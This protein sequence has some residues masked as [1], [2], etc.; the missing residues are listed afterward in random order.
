MTFPVVTQAPFVKPSEYEDIILRANP[1][2]SAIVRVKDVAR[3]EVGRRAYI[4][5]NRVNGVAATPIIVYQ[6]PG[7]NGLGT[8]FPNR[9]AR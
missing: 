2:G 9:S 6:Q 5:D 4:D 1:D 7:A 3:A 8:T